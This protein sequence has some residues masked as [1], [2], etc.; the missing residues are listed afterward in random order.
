MY[1]HTVWSS[2]Q[3]WLGLFKLL[4]GQSDFQDNPKVGFLPFSFPTSA[5]WSFQLCDL[6]VPSIIDTDARIQL[7]S[8]KP[9]IK[10]ICKIVKTMPFLL[11]ILYFKKQF[12]F[13]VDF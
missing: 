10:K 1:S 6:A 5:Q 3:L 2:D 8:L 12:L 13:N 9:D 7:S 4:Q 11:L